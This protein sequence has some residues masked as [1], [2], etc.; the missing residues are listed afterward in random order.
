[1]NIIIITVIV[2]IITADTPLLVTGTTHTLL[3][4]IQLRFETEHDKMLATIFRFFSN[5]FHEF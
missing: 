2:I 3:L 4:L 1:M 5:K